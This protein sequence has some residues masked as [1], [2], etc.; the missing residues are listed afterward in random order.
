[1]D[2]RVLGQA[3]IALVGTVIAGVLLSPAAAPAK[4]TAKTMEFLFQGGDEA[5]G[6]VPVGMSMTGKD[7]TQP[8]RV[9][10]FAI[11]G[12]NWDC[13]E[14]GTM[15][16]KDV[17]SLPIWENPDAA[18]IKRNKAKDLYFSW[19]WDETTNSRGD[20]RT[21][22]YQLVGGQH[23]KDPR[24][25]VGK[26]SMR[27][28]SVRSESGSTRCTMEGADADGFLQWKA[29]LVKACPGTC[30]SPF[31]APKALLVGQAAPR[32]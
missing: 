13:G 24:W 30:E 25:W 17:E 11:T 32:R 16:S 20:R 6:T 31:N 3:V 5:F 19:E 27:Y 14:A 29:R 2:I 23:R 7:P 4:T 26:V 12:F 28:S 21:V 15:P 22:S 1:M 18:K 9:T 8:T 10:D